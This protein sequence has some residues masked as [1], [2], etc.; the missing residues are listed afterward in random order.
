MVTVRA[1][2][3]P[4][5][6]P[7]TT[8]EPNRTT[9]SSVTDETGTDPSGE[10]AVPRTASAEPSIFR[11]GDF[12]WL[13]AAAAV[14]K[15]GTRISYVALPLVAVVTLH[16]S[17]GQVGLLGMLS[18]VAFLIVGLP[19]GAWLDTVR[20]RPVMV[21]ADVTRAALLASVPLGWWLGFLSIH[22]LY[23]VVLL[24]GVATVLFDVA[25]HSFLPHVVGRGRLVA[26]NS[27]LGTLNA[28]SSVAG[29]GAAGYL[30]Q[31][32]TA[33]FAVLVDAASY[34]CSAL[35]VVR[36]RGR[37][38]K[39]QPAPGSSATRIVEGVRH[40]AGHP[41]LRAVAVAGAVTNLCVHMLVVMLP[42]LVTRTLGLSVAMLGLYF[43]IGGLGALLGATLAG[44]VGGWLG[45]GRALWIVGVGL[46]P[47]GFLV[48]LAGDGVWLWLSAAG[49]FVT[50]LKIGVDNVIAV[51][52]RQWMTPDGL[53]GR[54]NATFRC[55]LT[56]ALAVGAGVAGLVGQFVGVRA[57]LWTAAAGL[58][59]VWIPLFLSPLR[60]TRDLTD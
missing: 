51:S 36:V 60:T 7:E 17:P 2:R 32:V 5:R 15:L 50:M 21:S 44:R 56:G 23:G 11:V 31:V 53:L 33:P 38:P 25:D 4:V 29:P 57:V 46:A 59:L 28:V 18:T 10:P 47:F 6:M 58:A 22:Q 13:F 34:L 41:M 9:P 35:C 1:A 27:K 45:H 42:V 54:M 26:A 48:P 39:P 3:Q 16:A 55:L 14:S 43:A 52:F 12:R 49:W 20:R 8:T 40:V 19:A 24:T 30:V 37:E